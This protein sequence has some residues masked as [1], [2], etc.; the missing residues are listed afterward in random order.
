MNIEQLVLASIADDWLS[1]YSIQLDYRSECSLNS[2]EAFAMMVP[3][4]ADWI[5]SGVVVPGDML[6][7][8]QPWQG[9]SD[10][11]AD[12]FAAAASRLAEINRPGE[13]C[14]FDLGPAAREASAILAEEM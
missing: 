8:F 10:E 7:G 12:R 6:D 9:N 2:K 1:D 11:M 5:R 13:I 4:L 14:W 3:R